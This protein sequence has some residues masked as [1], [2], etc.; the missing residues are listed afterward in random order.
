MWR[1]AKWLLRYLFFLLFLRSSHHVVYDCACA[2][3]LSLE[4]QISRVFCLLLLPVCFQDIKKLDFL[5]ISS[6]LWRSTKIFGSQ[7]RSVTMPFR[8][9]AKGRRP[10]CSSRCHSHP[11]YVYI[12]NEQKREKC[13][14]RNSCRPEKL[15]FPFLKI[16]L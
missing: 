16:F 12:F 11:L 5:T 2:T 10:G 7:L 14:L 13:M 3:S 1:F 8:P 9:V 6:V 15:R 4:T